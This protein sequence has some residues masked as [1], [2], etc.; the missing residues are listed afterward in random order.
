[1]PSPV[2]GHLHADFHIAQNHRSDWK[3]RDVGDMPDP[4]SGGDRWEKDA[5]KLAEGDADG[6]DGAGLDDEEEGPAEEE[7]PQ[8][9]GDS[10]R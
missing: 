1:M 6:S 5:E 8:R 2:G 3:G 10:R 4:V 9:S 7:A